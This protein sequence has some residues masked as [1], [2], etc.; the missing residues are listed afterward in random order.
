M[1]E[2]ADHWFAKFLGLEGCK[3]YCFPTDGEPRRT[4]D[5]GQYEV[6]GPDYDNNKNTVGFTVLAEF[7]SV[8]TT[9]IRKLGS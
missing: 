7:L 8:H 4:R 6:F 3:L 1:S 5:K 2:E 9:L